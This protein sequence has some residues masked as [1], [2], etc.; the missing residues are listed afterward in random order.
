M[1]IEIIISLF[2][3]P[4]NT[5]RFCSYSEKFKDLF[6]KYYRWL[7]ANPISPIYCNSKETVFYK[8]RPNPNQNLNPN[9]IQQCNYFYFKK[10][11]L[12]NI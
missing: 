9:E 4:K 3:T 10:I 8:R 7:R 1:V 12:I 5:K 2:F 6:M 11:Y